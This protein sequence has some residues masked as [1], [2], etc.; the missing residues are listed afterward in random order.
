MKVIISHDIDH[1]RWRDHLVRDLF[2]PKHVARTL[3]YGATGAIP[4]AAFAKR[5]EWLWRNQQ[6][7]LDRLVAF[8]A[9][10]SIPATY[11]VGVANGLGLSYSLETAGEL[12]RWL[13]D[14]G[15]THV[16][17]HGI[18]FDDP[19]E[20][21][22]ERERFAEIVGNDEFGIRMHYRR[23]SPRTLDLLG[24]AGYAFDSTTA[25]LRA[26][27]RIGKLV[28]FPISAMD[29][30]IMSLGRNTPDKARKATIARFERALQ[31]GTG[32][33]TVVFHDCYYSDAFP[34]HGSWYEWLV[35]WLVGEG[36]EFSTFESALRS[37]SPSLPAAPSID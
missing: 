2:L 1:W 6:H 10:H 7:N 15:C 3:Y 20:I 26:P 28:E 37:L 35:S 32:Y 17:V 18:A 24:E 8:N 31:L 12:V 14:R 16:G 33:F 5:F 36:V 22:R 25:E 9:A 29:V 27:Y 21:R 11:F 23:T 19:D 13:R 34:D 30:H 4:A